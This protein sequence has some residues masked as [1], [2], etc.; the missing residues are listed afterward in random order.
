MKTFDQIIDANMT[1]TDHLLRDAIYAVIVDA[2]F[3]AIETEREACAKVCETPIDEVQDTD[4][5]SHYVYMSGL[6]CA[7]AIRARGEKP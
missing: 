7:A 5:D 4:D 6:Q 3:E 2:I 1:V